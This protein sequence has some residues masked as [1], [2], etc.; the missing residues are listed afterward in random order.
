MLTIYLWFNAV[1]YVVLGVWCTA[2]PDATA[3][4][5]GFAFEKPGARSEYITVYGGMEFGLGVFFLL[6]AL[7]PTLRDA[8]L[9]LGL[10]MYGGLVAWRIGTF[11]TIPG[12]TG[13]PR[14]ALALEAALFVAALLLVWKRA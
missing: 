11:L 12:V 10:C 5:I 4:A 9:H 13:F 3:R 14:I 1:M 6:C 2:L 7:V 8:G